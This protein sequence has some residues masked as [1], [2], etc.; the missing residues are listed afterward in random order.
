MHVEIM[1]LLNE[2][3][4]SNRTG[5][6]IKSNKRER[7]V[8]GATVDSN[9]LALTEAHIRLVRKRCHIACAGVRSGSAAS[10]VRQPH[11]TVE[12]GYL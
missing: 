5:V 7:T 12:V 1:N 4:R 6:Q 3:G 9:E 11:E 8:M 2:I 10:D